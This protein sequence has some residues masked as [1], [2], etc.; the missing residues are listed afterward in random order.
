M[1]VVSGSVVSFHYT[2]LSDGGTVIDSSQDKAPITYLHGYQPLSVANLEEELTGHEAGEEI[3]LTLPPGQVF[4]EY[5]PRKIQE[6]PREVFP[7][8]IAL[9]PGARYTTMT[10]EGKELSFSVVD[11]QPTAVVIDFNHP[12]AGQE[13]VL[14]VKVE[15]VRQATPEECA[16]RRPL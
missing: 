3:V 5:D 4:G 11:L 9:T 7:P 16:Q 14:S 10:S 6:L 8:T 13:A 1:Q 15:E 2:L 12:L